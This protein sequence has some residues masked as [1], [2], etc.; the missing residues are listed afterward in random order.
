MKEGR[1]VNVDGYEMSLAGYEQTSA[2][3]LLAAPRRTTARCLVIELA[4]RPR[5]VVS[6]DLARFAALHREGRAVVSVE[7]PFW[8]EIKTL[9]THAEQLCADTLRWLEPVSHAV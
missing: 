6:A 9:Y 3:D 1:T 8:K 5:P 2:I 4:P 7:E